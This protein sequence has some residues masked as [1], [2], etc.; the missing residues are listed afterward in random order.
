MT[1]E[2]VLR[3]AQMDRELI[4]T[5]KRRKV[6]YLGHIISGENYSLLQTIMEIEWYAGCK[7]KADVLAA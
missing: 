2:E 7:Q 3:R 4:G 1:N 5:I 6:P